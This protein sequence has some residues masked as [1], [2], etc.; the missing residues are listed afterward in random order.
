MSPDAPPMR[1]GG[2]P[3]TSLLLAPVLLALATLP[4]CGGQLLQ[5]LQ[6][7]LRGRPPDCSMRVSGAAAAA[8]SAVALALWGGEG[9]TQALPRSGYPRIE[10]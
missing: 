6:H 9:Y 1:L 8:V 5:L 4:C 3:P 2:W 10:V 7:V